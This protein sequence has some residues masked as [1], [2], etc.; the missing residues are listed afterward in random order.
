MARGT[1]ATHR[2]AVRHSIASAIAVALGF[3]VLAAVRLVAGASF[4]ESTATTAFLAITFGLYG[5]I[6]LALTA[7]AFRGLHGDRLRALLVRSDERS[8]LV[9][10]F[11]LSGPKSWA[12]IVVF[13]GVASV[14]LLAT[15]DLERS[16]IWLPAICV[17]G[18]AGTWVL[19]VAVFA[20]DYMRSWANDHSLTFPGTEERTLRDFLY[21]SVQLS[22]TFSSSDVQLVRGSV[23]SLAIIHSV[24]AFAYSTAIIAVFA[25]LLISIA[26]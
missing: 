1:K 8:R 24:L 10:F 17:L 21:L 20:V 13:V 26:A 3:A 23:R 22:T 4:D 11:F 18:V 12:A 2:E 16:G 15:G 7:L 19:M 5:P 14:V 25:S 9:R 6:F